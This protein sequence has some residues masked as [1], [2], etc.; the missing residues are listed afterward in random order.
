M[1]CS[2][3]TVKDHPELSWVTEGGIIATAGDCV[4][5]QNLVTIR[6]A[7]N[8]LW[9]LL[10]TED[11]TLGNKYGWSNL[12]PDDPPKDKKEEIEPLATIKGFFSLEFDINGDL[13]QA[14]FLTPASDDLTTIGGRAYHGVSNY[15]YNSDVHMGLWTNWYG[16]WVVY[17]TDS[18]FG[19][20]GFGL[21][22]P[23]I[24]PIRRTIYCNGSASYIYIDDAPGMEV[25]GI[26]GIPGSFGADDGRSAPMPDGLC[27]LNF[28]WRGDSGTVGRDK[29][30][31]IINRLFPKT[32]C[33]HITDPCDVT[34]P[35]C[36]DNM[37]A[38]AYYTERWEGVN[39][40]AM[41][42]CGDETMTTRYLKYVS[43]GVK[44]QSGSPGTMEGAFEGVVTQ[45][46]TANHLNRVWSKLEYSLNNK[47]LRRCFHFQCGDGK[48]IWYHKQPVPMRLGSGTPSLAERL[49]NA[50]E[51]IC[52]VC[53]TEPVVDT[54]ICACQFN[55]LY[56]V[57][58]TYLNTACT[59]QQVGTPT[60]GQLRVAFGSN[61]TCD[62]CLGKCCYDCTC[63]EG[64][65]EQDCYGRTALYN[66][67][68]WIGPYLPGESEMDSKLGTMKPCGCYVEGDIPYNSGEHETCKET[69]GSPSPTDC[70]VCDQTI[71]LTQSQY[72]PVTG[73]CR[74]SECIC[75]PDETGCHCGAEC[76]CCADNERPQ[77]TYNTETMTNTC[78]CVPDLCNDSAGPTKSGFGG[79]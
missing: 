6:L 2:T 61:D 71:Y 59:C 3:D 73:M 67:P 22:W 35:M 48:H 14:L 26:W 53:N 8:D 12:V 42:P 27:N 41:T 38:T 31:S 60:E 70:G 50:E 43:V 66:G 58:K 46:I 65:T 72:D 9:D 78:T 28:D 68:L 64:V 45:V 33:A 20:T 32:V 57:I 24:G 76:C 62:C 4:S 19:C 17:L 63:E 16:P 75:C 10:D 30:V 79:I 15:T 55:E 52:E 47:N 37:Y 13:I 18:C 29:L 40:N 7:Y 1:S 5:W 49:R 77:L 54:N 36:C 74:P 56:H 21:E 44:E 25:Q 69:C 11:R 23:C 34:L 51:T 39:G